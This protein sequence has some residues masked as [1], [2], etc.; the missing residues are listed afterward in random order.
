MSTPTAPLTV[1]EAAVRY[2]TAFANASCLLAVMDGRDLTL[3]EFDSLSSARDT[4]RESKAT[5]AA[6]RM[7][8]LIE[9]A[10]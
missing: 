5:L 1:R 7:L 3:A 4:M 9:V 6:A 2:G 8:H 10:A